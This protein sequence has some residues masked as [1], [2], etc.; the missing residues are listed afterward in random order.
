LDKLI[1][2]RLF[3]P[4]NG[5]YH[6]YSSVNMKF[7]ERFQ[8]LKASFS[9][10]KKVCLDNSPVEIHPF[11][12]NQEFGNPE[13]QQIQQ[14][15]SPAEFCSVSDNYIEEN[16]TFSYPV[17]VP[18]G[19]IQ[20]NKAILLLHGLNERSWE[21]YLPWAEELTLKT[22]RA[23]ILFPI[24]F[25][26]NRTPK[27]WCNPRALLP[28]VNSRKEK[29]TG[30]NNSTYLNL[31]LSSRLSENPVRFYVSGRESVFNLWQLIREIKTGQHP[32]FRE[33]TSVN[34]FAY[35]I[36]A[37]LAQVLLL[38]NPEKLTSDS[39]LFM[40]CG[41]T[42]FSRMNGNSRDIMDRESFRKLKDYFLKDFI[43]RGLDILNRKEDFM[44]KAFKSMLSSGKYSHYRETF[45]Q[46]AQNRIAA[47]GLK[48]DIVIPTLGIKEA[49]GKACSGKMLEEL[50][51]PY[52]YSHQIPFPVH[53][54]VAPE[55]VQQSFSGIFDR[56]AAF[57]S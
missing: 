8:Q 1:L 7:I 10:E 29:Y 47:V 33:N 38:S 32:L 19:E 53:N 42:L 37:F 41:G 2:F 30:L 46:E 9:Y 31:A 3:A 15:I 55:M 56:A 13:I 50:D 57:L 44:E 11:R 36:G 34:L 52:E 25:H 17:F 27:S 45:F 35:S 5:I 14:N 28:Y 22:G 20:S 16:K 51:F 18:K 23:V 43:Y 21:K 49:F 4:A 24:A 40:F 6:F 26:M 12:F 39:R 54:R 48:K